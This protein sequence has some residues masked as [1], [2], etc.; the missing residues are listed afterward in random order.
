MAFGF[1]F[2]L[3]LALLALASVFAYIP[4]ASEFAFWLAIAAYFVLLGSRR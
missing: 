1:L 2:S 3:A 4:Y